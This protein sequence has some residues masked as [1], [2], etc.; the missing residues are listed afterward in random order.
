MGSSKRAAR[1]EQAEKHPM[2]SSLIFASL[3]T[4][5]LFLGF[6]LETHRWDVVILAPAVFCGSC[7]SMYLVLTQKSRRARKSSN[8]SENG[9]E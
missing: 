8:R 5:G 6:G 4:V 2:R 9:Y 1:R 7:L 3:G